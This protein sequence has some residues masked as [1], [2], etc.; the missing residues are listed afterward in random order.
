M[1]LVGLDLLIVKGGCARD[2]GNGGYI[3]IAG[4]VIL[5]ERSFC[6]LCLTKLDAVK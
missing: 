2:F 6:G 1:D 4:P 5:T 3:Y